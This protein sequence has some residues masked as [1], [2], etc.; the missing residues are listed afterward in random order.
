M[1][2]T[3]PL[4]SHPEVSCSIG[5]NACG[6]GGSAIASHRAPWAG[7]TTTHTGGA[8]WRSCRQAGRWARCPRARPTTSTRRA[9]RRGTHRCPPARPPPRSCSPTS[10][11]VRL[12]NADRPLPPAAGLAAGR[13]AMGA[14][15]RHK[16]GQDVLPEQPDRRE[17]LGPTAGRRRAARP[18]RGG[19]G[20]GVR[21]GARQLELPRRRG[22]GGGAALAGGGGRGNRRQWRWRWQLCFF[23]GA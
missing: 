16:H 1:A 7:C 19:R 8:G 6:S 3:L 14:V 15:H 9:S 4:P 11:P 22:G 21:R 5:R 10:R 12:A 20:C 23:S 17:Q 18:N 13:V 2:A